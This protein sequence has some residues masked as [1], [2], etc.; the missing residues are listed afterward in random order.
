MEEAEE[1]EPREAHHT[2][3]LGC[4]G[5]VGVDLLPNLDETVFHPSLPPVPGR[6]E[7]LI[8]DRKGGEDAAQEAAVVA[9][10]PAEEV[11]V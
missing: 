3:T 2:G 10:V 9:G 6:K 11:S 7:P 1:A 4:L 5:E 8:L